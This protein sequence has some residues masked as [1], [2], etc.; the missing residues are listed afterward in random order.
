MAS[1]TK[2]LLLLALTG[3]VLIYIAICAFMLLEQNRLLYIGTILP[4]HDPALILP[5]FTDAS[6]GL[7]GW[8]AEPAGKAHGTVVFFHGNDEEA[9]QADRDYAAYFTA[10]GLRV[11]F[12]EY[13]GFDMRA[14]L[15][16]THDT[17]IADAVV[18]VALARHRWPGAPIWVAGNSLGAG[19]A[20]QAAATGGVKRVLLFVPWDSMGAVAAER[21]P[22]IPVRLLLWAGGTDYDSCAALSPSPAKIFVTYAG[23]DTIIPT[24]HAAALAACLGLPA[25]Q[26]LELPGA[27]HL[28]WDR[29]MTP[30]QWDN[31]LSVTQ[32]S[33]ITPPD[34][35]KTQ[36]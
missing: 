17:V 16:P 26:T 3:A 18:D 21:Y 30:A 11:V 1:R 31:L 29:H 28:D 4:P 15:A 33:L 5:P 6:G 13:R 22:L 32:T 19:I 35:A 36:P 9:W 27:G 12:P 2:N 8:V 24:H 34:R 25:G 20:A 10:R 7:I 14:P 23:R